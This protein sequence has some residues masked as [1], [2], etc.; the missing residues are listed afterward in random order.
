MLGGKNMAA[1]RFVPLGLIAAAVAL[2][3]ECK[4][5]FPASPLPKATVEMLRQ[6]KISPNILS[7]ID[8]ELQVP[9]DWIEKAKKEGRIIFHVPPTSGQVSTASFE[10]RYPFIKIE[11]QIS[12]ARDRAIKTLV[13]FKGG[14]MPGDVLESA[15]DAIVEFKKS[16]AMSDLRDIPAWETVLDGLK[17][18]DGLW[19]GQTVSIYCMAY[20]TKL[21]KTAD[22]PAKWEDL[23]A[24]PAWKNGNLGL[25]DRPSN[26]IVGL[27]KLKGPEWTTQF[28]TRLFTEL[29]PQRRKEGQG[30]AIALLGAGEFHAHI[31][32]S[33]S[34]TFKQAEAGLPVSLHCPDPVPS[35]LSEQFIFR[36]APHP[37]AA[38]IYVNWTLTK[39]G[40]LARQALH[41]APVHKDLQR[42]EFI[43]Y[44]DTI[45]GKQRA[46]FNINDEINLLPTISPIWQKLWLGK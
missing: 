21:A 30:A 25:V 26:W 13:A 23:P 27:W 2:M 38:K 18:P 31:P 24:I 46:F 43:R 17:D 14:R 42:K 29:K 9:A 44:G 22:L 4:Q 40:Q 20:N 1:G 35:N 19:V 32:A 36:G 16:N 34:A 3:L 11:K 7:D 6:L 39:E 41:Y 37:Y 33:Q 10:E 15:G 45:V 12:S 28:M 5:A 8:K